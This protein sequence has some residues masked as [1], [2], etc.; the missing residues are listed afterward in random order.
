MEAMG[1][2]SIC[3]QLPVCDCLRS[4]MLGDLPTVQKYYQERSVCASFDR[5][6]RMVT[7]ELTS[8]HLRQTTPTT[9]LP[10]QDC[11]L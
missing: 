8:E 4:V 11:T 3:I 9:R 1:L 6:Q 5:C 10:L 7:S 2:G